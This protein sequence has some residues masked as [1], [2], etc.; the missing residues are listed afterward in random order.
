MIRDRICPFSPQPS[1]VIRGRKD[2]FWRPRRY[3][4]WRRTGRPGTRE[5]EIEFEREREREREIPDLPK[6]MRPRTSFGN[7]NSISRLAARGK[8]LERCG[9]ELSARRAP[10]YLD[11]AKV[12]ILRPAHYPL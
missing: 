10:L 1:V 12:V 6:D 9:G 2:G 4:D 8:A 7:V 11:G 3:G 5:K